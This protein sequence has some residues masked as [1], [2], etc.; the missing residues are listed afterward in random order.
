MLLVSLFEEF[1]E[2]FETLPHLCITLVSVFAIVRT[3]CFF[4]RFF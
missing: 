4:L 2:T 3:G 1:E